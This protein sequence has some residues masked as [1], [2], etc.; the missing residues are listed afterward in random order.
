M[1]QSPPASQPIP[2]MSVTLFLVL[3]SP[4]HLEQHLALYS[5][6]H[7]TVIGL[8][9][10]LRLSRLMDQHPVLSSIQ[11]LLRL[12]TSLLTSM[13]LYL[14]LVQSR[15]RDQHPLLFSSQS[16]VLLYM[17]RPT[18]MD[19]YLVLLPSRPLEQLQVLL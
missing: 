6:Q 2:F 5:S 1:V 10:T 4:H 15:L 18:S 17:S 3:L 8:F 19:M 11:G 7:L 16:L 9:L 12:N 13:V 14:A